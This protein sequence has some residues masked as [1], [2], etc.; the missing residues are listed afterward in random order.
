ML[1]QNI[2]EGKMC[3]IE[4]YKQVIERRKVSVG[5]LLEDRVSDSLYNGA[6]SKVFT[7]LNA[8]SCCDRNWKGLSS[9][10]FQPSPDTNIIDRWSK[11]ESPAYERL[12]TWVNEYDN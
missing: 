3:S 6:L 5:E 7:E 4:N 10:I 8:D 1:A 11:Q 9:H 2:L 12:C